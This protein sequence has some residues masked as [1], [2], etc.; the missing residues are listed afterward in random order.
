MKITEHAGKKYLRQIHSSVNDDEIDVD[1]YEI[2]DAYKCNC[3][4]RQ[5]AI[6]KL[7]LAGLRQK[8]SEIQD[9]EEARNSVFRA[10]EMQRRR[11]RKAK[12]RSNA[13]S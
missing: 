5:H 7:L 3:P 2:L 13:K 8:G 12:R 6:K 11:E 4:A 9:L 10:I 1:I